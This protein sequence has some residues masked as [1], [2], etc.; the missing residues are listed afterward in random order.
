[1]GVCFLKSTLQT[2]PEGSVENVN[3]T[4]FLP[5]LTN[6][7]ASQSFPL[8]PTPPPL[9]SVSEMLVFSASLDLSF[10][11]VLSCSGQLTS[12]PSDVSFQLLPSLPSVP[13]LGFGLHISPTS[14]NP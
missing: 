12:E 11:Q 4:L 8:T 5:Y 13:L 6:S 14:Y 1:M 2:Q 3:Q 9:V 10:Y 7:K